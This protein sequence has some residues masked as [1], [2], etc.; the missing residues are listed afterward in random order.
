MPSSATAHILVRDG[1][2]GTS[3]NQVALAAGVSV[4][5]LHQYFR[6]S[7]RSSSSTRTR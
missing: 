3:T 7:P 5:S 2:E 6:S 4:G 1:Y